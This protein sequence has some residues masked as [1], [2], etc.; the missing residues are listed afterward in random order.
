MQQEILTPATLLD[1]SGRLAVKGYARKFNIHYNREQVRH[2][3]LKLKEWN[4]YQIQKDHYVLQMTLGHV[5]YMCSV[6][7]TLLD[8]DTGKRYEFGTMKPLFIPELDKNPETDSLVSFETTDFSLSF[9]VAAQ[10]RILRVRGSS[11]AYR[12]VSID[13]ELDNDPANEKMVIATPFEKPTQF[14]LNYKENYYRGTGTVQFDDLRLDF[15]D[16]TGLLDW[17][18]G[19]WPYSHQW[20]WGS[21]TSH[22]DGVPFGFNIGWG[23]G[24]L[25]HATEN[26]FFYDKKAYKLG[27]L[28]V[29]RDE[30]DYMKPWKFTDPE[31]KLQ[32]TL[33]PLFDNYTENKYVVIDT[34]CNQVFGYFDGVIE[35]DSGPKEF[36]HIL[37]F[38]EHAVN[39][40]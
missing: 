25:S 35:T 6:S 20:F 32:M 18:R 16:C 38:V 33:T 30:R 9:Q 1:H 24:D 34:H 28:Q 15:D 5:S 17:G 4:F 2:F 19:V 40:W 29:E 13:I 21:L 8:L 27:V 3:P 14:Y 10:K 22:I 12:N 23:F 11:K 26:M 31:R 36:R 39:H 37:A 7:A